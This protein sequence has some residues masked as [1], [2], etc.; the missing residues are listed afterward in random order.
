MNLPNG[1]FTA[2]LMATR[3]GIAVTTRLFLNTLVQYNSLDR[4]VTSNIRFQ[5]IFRPGSDLYLVFNE[6]RGSI[7]SLSTP[8]ARAARLK[9]TY[10]RRL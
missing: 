5:Y 8:Q 7:A 9:V 10:L 4:R 3:I 2:D 6:E 1:A